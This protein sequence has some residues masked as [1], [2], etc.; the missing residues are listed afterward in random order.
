[1]N[2]V[3]EHLPPEGE[4]SFFAKAFDLP[5]F[6]TPWHYH[7]E[8]ELVYI[9]TS[10]GKRIIG[11]TVSEFKAGDLTF[12]GPNLPHIYKNPEEYYR[13]DPNFRANSIVIHFLEKSIG[14]DFLNLPQSKNLRRLFEQS[15]HGIDIYGDTKQMVIGK[16]KELLMLK[17][18]CRL[19]CLL[20]I[21]NLLAETSEY[22]LISPH[23]IITHNALDADR[24]EKVFEF[25]FHNFHNEIKL[26]E[27][28][29]IACMTRT[30]FCRYFKERTKRTFSD[31]LMDFRLKHAAKLLR[32]GNLSVIQISEESG[33]SNLSNFNRKF[34]E[35]YGITP[36]EFR[37]NF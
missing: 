7:P 9:K 19:I 27:V 10:L 30:S 18:M 32:E 28:A 1:M 12:L 20:D 13:N 23:G 35:K 37:K 6:G 2:A 26:K 16:M 11:T 3:L 34:K 24:M 33:Y 29:T 15:V 14:K 21:L 4:E 22:R 25:V 36:K 5:Y 8:F 31:F 17:G